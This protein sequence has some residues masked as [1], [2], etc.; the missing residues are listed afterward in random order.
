[1][2][3]EGKFECGQVPVLEIDGKQL[4]QSDAILRHVGMLSTLY[5]K[6]DWEAANVD[7]CVSIANEL[8][9]KMGGVF[10]S[11]SEAMAKAAVEELMPF[12]RNWCSILERRLK[13][14]LK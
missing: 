1:M 10:I 7:A 13:N 14:N 5:P 4:P 12:A 11:K 8:S 6:D 3:K 9:S 2:K